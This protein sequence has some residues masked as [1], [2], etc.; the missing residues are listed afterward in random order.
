MALADFFL[1]GRSSSYFIADIAANHDGSLDRAKRL[2]ELAAQSGAD[3]AKFQHFRAREIVSNRGFLELGKAMAHQ[4][5]WKKSVIEVYEDAAVPWEWT[6]KLKLHCDEVGIE[7]LSTPYDLEAVAHL[8][9]YVEA[10]KVGSGDI[11]FF[12]L[13]SAVGN[14]GKPVLLATGAASME[15][16]REAVAVL[17]QFQVPITVMQCNTNYTGE[18]ENSSFTNLRV[19]ETFRRE[20]PNLDLGLSDHTRS[21][22][23]IVGAIA[24]GARVIERHFTDDQTRIGPDHQF[25]MTPSAWR[26]MVGHARELE[27][28]LG[29]GLKKTEANE[30]EAR[31]VQRRCLRY[32]DKLLEGAVVREQDLVALRPAPRNSIPPSQVSSIVG[33]RLVRNVEADEQVFEEDFE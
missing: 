10:F 24:L 20:F 14:T 16:V 13:L 12:G 17:R 22:G 30:I 6:E 8:D 27:A 33:K 11:D 25:S 1:R 7:F 28:A 5:G 21:L 9:P 19:L 4:A 23:T 15:E 2:I 3:A 29:D 26:E 31:I 18:Q 32:R